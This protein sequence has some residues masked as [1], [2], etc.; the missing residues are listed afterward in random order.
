[1][2]ESNLPAGPADRTEPGWP[3]AGCTPGDLPPAQ[4]PRRLT[5][6][7]TGSGSEYFR[8][9]I[10][11]LLLSIVTLGLY[12]PFAKARRLS[13]FYSN[14]LIDGQALAFHGNPWKML[15]G[16]LL[17]AVLGGAYA[18]AGHF[19][20][21]G[22]VVAFGLLCVIW[23]ALWRAGLQFRLANTSWRG[24]RFGFKG[25]LAGA[26]KAVAPIYLPT[27]VIV[28]VGALMRSQMEAGAT[29]DKAALQGLLIWNGSAALLLMLLM[30]W[31]LA[32]IKRYQHGGYAYASQRAELNVSTWRFYTLSLKFIGLFLLPVFL[33][34]IVAA[35]VIPMLKLGPTA[36]FVLIGL[37]YFATLALALPFGTA[38]LQDLIWNGTRSAELRFHSALKFWPFAGLTVA[39]WLLTALTLS[40]YRPFA[41]VAQTRMRLAAMSIELSG[42][43]DSWRAQSADDYQDASGDAAGDFFGI[44]MGL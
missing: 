37:G 1:M 28:I 24:L 32:L 39:N 25:E 44:D 16:F 38:R 19:S 7:F 13:Y 36:M 29:P 20:P 17:L 27:L 2:S 31:A 15:R 30:P 34:G 22:A 14:T 40:L 6:E 41:A 21:L 5:I 12:L 9:W 18:A 3:D 23:P 42:D 26:Y 8:I 10:V 43:L 11:N 4:A 35:V 33:M